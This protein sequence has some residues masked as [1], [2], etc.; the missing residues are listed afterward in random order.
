MARVINQRKKDTN[1]ALTN[2][3]PREYYN[4]DVS[5][6]RKWKGLY[7]MKRFIIVVVMLVALIGIGISLPRQ[8]VHA[9]AATLDTT[10]NYKIENQNSGLVLDI[11][12]ASKAAGTAAIQW[13]DNGG[14]NQ[15]W[16]FISDGGGNYKIENINSGELLGISGGSTA[17][18]VAALQWADN[19]TRDHL[20]Q[21]VSAGNGY[22]KIVN[23]NS[24]LVLGISNASKTAGAGA[25][26]WTDNGTSDHL[27][28]L[29]AAGTTYPNPNT[30]SGDI[31]VHDPAMIKTTNGTYYAFSTTTSA[32]GIEMRSS[33]DR[34][35]F[36]NAGAAFKTIPSWTRAYNGGNGVLWAPDV[37]YHNGKYWLYYAA[38]S[39]GSETSAIGLAT[40]TTAAPGSWVDQGIVYTSH[41]GSGF[42]AIDPALSS[43]ASGNYW[44]NLG[45]YWNGIYLIQ[46]NPAT[47]KQL[48]S[49][50]T[51][52]HL[53]VRLD[54][55][56]GIEGAYI[57]HHG[58][59]Y[60]LFAS[61]DVCCSGVNSTYHIVV[62]RASSVTGPY[63]DEGGVGMLQG[64]GTILL[65]SHGTIVGPGGNTVMHDTD[66]DLLVYH[67]YNGNNNGSPTLGLNL[68]GWDAQGWPYVR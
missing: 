40:S 35:H 58:S 17:A 47:G 64:G 29:V 52:Y 61:L 67:Y 10:H 28:K 12:G 53:A 15:L 57:Y 41:P 9:A 33:P 36:T 8:A 16:H 27:W 55:S 22:Y 23:Q 19:G 46:I 3:S 60:Y 25:L 26:Q 56:K 14:V 59:Y 18:G 11:S 13:T 20:W 32:S 50:Q 44:L 37:S 34:I 30:V 4:K 24:G 21:F 65:S 63:T 6:F 38:S 7:S 42:N 1:Q 49:N 43:D 45:S 62:G 66:G 5:T 2:F 51:L 31:T 39:F 68:L 48:A 54:T